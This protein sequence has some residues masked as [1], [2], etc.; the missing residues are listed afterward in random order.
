MFVRRRLE[1]IAWLVGLAILLTQFPIG[2]CY[3]VAPRLPYRSSLFS[4]SAADTSQSSN[5][6]NIL[7]FDQA[8]MSRFACKS[9]Q[10][11]NA[12]VPECVTA[13][14]SDPEIIRQALECIDMARLAPSSFNTQPYKVVMVHN[15]EQKLALSRYCLGPNA[16]RVR[17]ADCTAVFLADRKVLKTL[18]RF[19]QFL[20]QQNRQMTKLLAF[21]IAV[22]SSGYPL[23]RILSAI[24]SFSFRWAMSMLNIVTRILRLPPTL[25][26]LSSTETWSTKNAMLVAMTYMLACS[27]RGLATIPMEGIDGPGIRRVLR[28]PSRYAIPLVI[29]TGRAASPMTNLDWRSRRYPREEMIYEN[30]FGG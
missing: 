21:Y 3:S 18:P 30:Q 6:R 13:S 23:P 19:S 22:F 1:L 29:A 26:T 2:E 8:V 28:I 7:S 15:P 4:S 17:D 20:Q 9:F 24:L 25:P 12:T 10:R 16:D 27:S 14:P 5:N 11:A